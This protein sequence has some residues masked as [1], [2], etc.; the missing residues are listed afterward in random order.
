MILLIIKKLLI[1]KINILKIPKYLKHIIITK[2][3]II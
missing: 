3:S 2:T 1:E